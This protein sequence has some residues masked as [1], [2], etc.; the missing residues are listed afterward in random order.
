MRMIAAAVF[1]SAM[2]FGT[3]AWA[4][5]APSAAPPQTPAA[6]PST[7][8]PSPTVSAPAVAPVAPTAA[9]AAT[10][11][12]TSSVNLDEIVCRVQPPP[13]GSRF[14]GGRECHT[15]RQWNQREKDSQDILTREQHIGAAGQPGG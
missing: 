5:D 9:A 4:A 15:V 11:S 1:S 7:V 6:S 14:G 8:A 12:T 3:I 10:A 13:T 2:L